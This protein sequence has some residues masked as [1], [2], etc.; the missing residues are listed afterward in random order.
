MVENISRFVPIVSACWKLRS[1]P[2]GQLGS[3][4]LTRGQNE[5]RQIEIALNF[6]F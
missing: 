5:S 6:N 1:G 2:E 3:D 4:P